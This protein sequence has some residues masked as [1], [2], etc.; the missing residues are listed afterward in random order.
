MESKP[1]F[2][3]SIA[4]RISYPFFSFGQNIVY[5]LVT[6][7]L[8]PFYTD[9]IQLTPY[10]VSIILLLAKVWD[11]VNDPLFGI[12]VD[13][14]HF[15]K[16]KFKPWLRISTFLIPL[17]TFLMFRISPGLP[18]GTKIALAVVTY[19]IWDMAYTVSD[20]PVFSMLTAMTGNVQERT[21]MLSYG[22]VGTVAAAIMVAIVFSP[23][24]DLGQYQ[25]VAT[26]AAICALVGMLPLT[27][28]AKERNRA[29]VTA[30]EEKHSLKDVLSYLKQNKYL[31]F[32]YLFVCING[33]AA[34]PMTYYILTYCFGSYGLLATMMAIGVLPTL[35]LYLLVPVITKKVDRMSLY[36]FFV[37]TTLALT[38][39]TYFVGYS[40]FTLYAALAIPKT[41]LGAVSGLLPYT[42]AMDCVEFG[43]YKTGMRKEGVTF[44]VQT[45]SNKFTAAISSS[46]A[47]FILGLLAYNAALEVQPAEM[48]NSIWAVA[49]WVPVAGTLIGLPFLFQFK[50]KSKD[51]Q[52]MADINA[53]HISREEGDVLMSRSY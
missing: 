44:A 34:I 28:V 1:R 13:R 4:E 30:N 47:A 12:I 37:L 38:V 24:I 36:R 19:F 27:I 50:L 43:H 49:H 6:A 32:F 29:G 33:A 48:L 42:F 40:N 25:Q 2:Q 46:L 9:Y 51:A 14:T 7:L 26:I 39:V 52:I 16:N 35:I 41:V 8:M 22:S 21:T 18:V 45:F 3:T 17:T 11:A 15:K 53:G 23:M 31:L 10:V 20:V 5:G